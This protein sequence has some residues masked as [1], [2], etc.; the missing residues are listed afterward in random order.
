MKSTV[1]TIPKQFAE[2]TIISS[3]PRAQTSDAILHEPKFEQFGLVLEIF[4]GSARLTRAFVEAGAEA[5]SVDWIRNSSK[6]SG[7]TVLL[8]LTTDAGKQIIMKLI[9]ERRVIS[10]HFAPPCGTASRAREK[11][12]SAALKAQGCVEPKPLRNNQY[13]EGL[14]SNVGTDA[15]KV[16]LANILY[17]FTAE[18]CI[19]AHSLGILFSVENPANSL[20]WLTSWFVTLISGSG[21]FCTRFPNCAHG[22]QRP[23]WSMFVHN[24]CSLQE[25]EAICP[26]EGPGHVHL[27]WGASKQQGSWKFA[28]SDET[29]YPVPLCQAI[30]RLVTK[31]LA[32]NNAAFLK[33]KPPISD[34]KL[35]VPEV[36]EPGPV[37]KMAK[38]EAG[39]QPRGRQSPIL[40]PDYKGV[41]KVT[42][43]QEQF[44]RFELPEKLTSQISFGSPAVLVPAGSKVLRKNL[45]S[46]GGSGD[47]FSYDLFFAVPWSQREFVDKAV[48]LSHPM[49][50]GSSLAPEI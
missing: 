36:P 23:K 26:G 38:T 8:D 32:V 9:K 14:P 39:R 30:A 2:E 27:P 18:M 24:V 17:A 50:T 41:C 25:L 13:P 6:P 4:G 46:N 3:L 44:D 22:G 35:P 28:T 15:L 48:G 5:F 20:M 40:I 43:T 31:Q 45:V 10:I 33:L 42:G 11:P 7:P 21:M 1:Q 19:L 37:R 47:K 16:G 12:I 34:Q 49:D 29:A